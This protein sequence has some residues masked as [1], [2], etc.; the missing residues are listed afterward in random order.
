MYCTAT[1]RWTPPI[2]DQLKC[3]EQNAEF[4]TSL[5]EWL[6]K[7][8]HRASDDLFED[9]TEH[10]DTLLKKNLGLDQSGMGP[11]KGIHRYELLCSNIADE[12]MPWDATETDW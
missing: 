7:K 8:S 5:Q 10:L 3:P 9:L 2:F 12:D 6:S 11:G 1:S 4:Y